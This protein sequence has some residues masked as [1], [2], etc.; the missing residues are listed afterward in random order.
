MD[1]RIDT[2]HSG[3]LKVGDRV[4]LT[5]TFQEPLRFGTASLVGLM[6]LQS[7]VDP[8][9]L[10]TTI[11][12][13][14][15]TFGEDS[16]QVVVWGL[17]PVCAPGRYT[18]NRLDLTLDGAAKTYT[19]NDLPPGLEVDVQSSDVRFPAISTIVQTPPTA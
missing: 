6:L 18:L 5:V 17:V 15:S 4:S 19:G 11:S 10:G 9:G 8:K 16:K 3:P 7:G 12:L 2:P 13:N 1:A 14:N